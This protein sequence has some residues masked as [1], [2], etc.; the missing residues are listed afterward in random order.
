MIADRLP[1]EI[2]DPGFTVG[3]KVTEAAGGRTIIWLVGDLAAG[4]GGAISVRGRL[5]PELT[6]PLT[7]TNT[8]MIAGLGDARPENNLAEAVLRVIDVSALKPAVWLPLIVRP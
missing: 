4:A 8:A 5:N 1:A 6:G 7:I 2:I 3:G